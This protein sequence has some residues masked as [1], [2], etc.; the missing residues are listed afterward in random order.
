MNDPLVAPHQPLL[1]GKQQDSRD[2]LSTLEPPE[3][4]TDLDI[5]EQA[6][7]GYRMRR[8]AIIVVVCYLLV[9]PLAGVGAYF[10]INNTIM[11]YNPPKG[12]MVDRTIALSNDVFA[13]QMVHN[14]VF[15]L[16][17]SAVSGVPVFEVGNGALCNL[18]NF[19]KQFESN[20]PQFTHVDGY[21]EYVTVPVVARNFVSSDNTS[22]LLIAD[23]LI[24]GSIEGTGNLQQKLIDAI[25]TEVSSNYSALSVKFASVEL[26]TGDLMSG[27]VGDLMTIDAISVPC[28][29]LALAIC[30]RSVRMLILPGAVLPVVILLSFGI[31]YLVS[32]AV[33]VS[34]FAPEMAS[35][36]T[37]AIT[38]DYSLFIL[39]RFSE[40]APRFEMRGG[41]DTMYVR[42]R[43]CL[44]TAIKCAHNIIVSGLT[45]AVALG[46]LVLMSVQLISSIGYIFFISGIVAVCVSLTLMP[47]LLFIFYPF[48]R[49]ET[50]FTAPFRRFSRWWRNSAPLSPTS[51]PA[52][53]ESVSAG[54][55]TLTGVPVSE[56][57]LS[58]RRVYSDVE[59]DLKHVNPA[60]T[61]GAEQVEYLDVLRRQQYSSIWF[62]MGLFAHRHPWP[63][64]LLVMVFGAPFCWVTSKLEVDFSLFSQVPRDSPHGATLQYIID[65]IGSGQATPFYVT[66]DTGRANGIHDNA[67]E[68]FKL[69]Q[70][71]S[72]TLAA[73]TGQSLANFD[74]FAFADGVPIPADKYEI[75]L[76][77]LVEPA[78]AVLWN[79]TLDPTLRAGIIRITTDFDAFAAPANK[80]LNDLYAVL[81]EFDT[82]GLFTIGLMGASTVSWAIMREVMGKFPMQI[83]ITFGIIFILIAGVFRSVLVP[84]RMI[85]TVSY[86]VAVSLGIGVLFFQ[87]SWS[88]S[89]WTSMKGIN[90]YSWTV[91]I[92]AFSLLCALALDYDVFLLT[93]LVE[94][95]NL[96]F[97][98]EA[99]I[100]K[101]VWRTGRIVS[102]AGI[103]M[104]IS[105]G[106][107]VFSDITMLNQFGFISAVAVLLDSFVIRGLFVPALMS[108]APKVA[109]WPRRFPAPFRGLDDMTA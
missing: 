27:L 41:G 70:D 4:L 58:D 63:V 74:S 107:M 47:S 65:N 19:I 73:R 106:S 102:F 59:K 48:F 103:I 84:F 25:T 77:M 93:R 52:Q 86:T 80:F 101:S 29:M 55:P 89:F 61:L 66:I 99:A 71:L 90:S 49:K 56:S 30:L 26:V 15:M 60:E 6:M 42:Y 40:V 17:Q 18:T 50:D 35:A 97:T 20:T 34:S 36:T 22:S 51:R 87:Y 91:P 2:D 31:S 105:F 109:W 100:A 95:H 5:D 11:M 53:P 13:K 98:P 78:F 54:A 24:E 23:F 69:V 21:C 14:P 43:V 32:L 64:I 46:G 16:V 88:H 62:K 81:E 37:L 1:A 45:I 12:S 28:A 104:A 82:Q 44:E 8:I 85:L 3:P 75:E 67:T 72:V 83:G 38:I 96:A 76:F 94:M 68:I 79:N 7:L 92:F 33:E 39:S 108:I 57:D 10:F 9:L